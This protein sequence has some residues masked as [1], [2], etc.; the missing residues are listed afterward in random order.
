MSGD[1]QTPDGLFAAL[2]RFVS[3]ISG[4]DVTPPDQHEVDQLVALAT[5][6]VDRKDIRRQVILAL[7]NANFTRPIPLV[8]MPA[9]AEP[10]VEYIT[11]GPTKEQENTNG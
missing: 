3:W 4:P 7:L 5:D 9:I 2:Q 6:L 10:L 11:N 1:D 8:D